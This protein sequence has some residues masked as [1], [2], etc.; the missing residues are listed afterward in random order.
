MS[1]L[2]REVAMGSD[3]ERTEQ[4][5]AQAKAAIRELLTFIGEDP[6]REG[7]VET[8][9]RVIDAMRDHF[10]GYREDPRSH[11]SKTFTEVEGY[12]EFLQ[13]SD[14]TM[15]GSADSFRGW[16]GVCTAGGRCPLLEEAGEGPFSRVSLGD[17]LWDVDSSSP[18]PRRGC[19]TGSR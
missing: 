15:V 5:R 10:R 11:L 14:L 2:E 6:D 17:V 8:P 7:L 13:S 18:S 3:G 9:R 16:T 19:S 12:N 4:A 1:Q